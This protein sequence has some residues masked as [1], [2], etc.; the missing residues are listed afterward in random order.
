MTAMRMAMR[1]MAPRTEVMQELTA[2][3]TEYLF[4]GE[5]LEES[6]LITSKANLWADLGSRGQMAAA[7]R[8]AA[9]QPAG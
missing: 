5:I 8:Q 6:R 2:R 4:H 1:S 9:G 3:R 7:V